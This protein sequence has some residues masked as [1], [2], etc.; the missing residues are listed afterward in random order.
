ME[1]NGITRIET[2]TMEAIQS[3][4]RSL[5]RIAKSLEGI[6]AALNKLAAAT[7]AL[8]TISQYLAVEDDDEAAAIEEY[9]RETLE[10]RL[11]K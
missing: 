6:E 5:D 10:R 7:P 2:Q 9:R 4:A 11:Q 8:E 1:I 3:S